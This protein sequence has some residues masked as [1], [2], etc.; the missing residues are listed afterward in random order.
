MQVASQAAAALSSG[1]GAFYAI[2]RGAASAPVMGQLFE[3]RGISAK[4]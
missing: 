1:A 4:S 2:G 3:L